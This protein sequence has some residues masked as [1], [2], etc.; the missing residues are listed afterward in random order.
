MLD[1][2]I[3][4]AI[5]IIDFCTSGTLIRLFIAVITAVECCSYLRS[6]CEVWFLLF[7]SLLWSELEFYRIR[8]LLF[9]HFSLFQLLLWLLLFRCREFGG[10]WLSVLFLFLVTIRRLFLYQSWIFQKGPF[11]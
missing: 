5:F 6:P 4:L 10:L 11:L 9:W 1:F 3:S 2:S 7:S 8:C